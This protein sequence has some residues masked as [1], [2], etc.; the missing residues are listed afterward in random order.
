M[1]KHKPH[2]LLAVL[3][4]A[5]TITIGI[6]SCKKTPEDIGLPLLPGSDLLNASFTDAATLTTH[7]V[8]DDSVR[9]DEASVQLLGKYYDPIFGIASSSLYA[10]MAP[11]VFTPN[12][13]TNPLLDSAVLSLV[14][15]NKTY[16]GTLEPQMFKVYEIIENI[17]YDAN[18]YSNRTLKKGTELGSI[19]ITPNVKDS[20]SVGAGK[21][22]AHIRINLRD[23][24]FQEF[25]TNTTNYGSNSSFQDFFKGIYVESAAGVSTGYGAIFSIDLQHTYSRISLFYHNDDTT[26]QVIYFN[27][28][29]N[30][31]SCGRFSHFE[32]DYSVTTDVKAQLSSS[33][34][35]Q[36]DKIY[37]QPMGGVRTK[38]SM[39][40]IEN[41]FAGQKV[42]INKA[43]LI[44]HA[45]PTAVDSPYYAHSK[46]IATIADSVLGPAVMPDYYEGDSYFGGSYDAT[47]K[48]YKFNIA[49]Y[50]QQVVNGT[51]EN[52]GLYIIANSRQITVNRTQLIGG[53]Q[54]LTNRMRL[55]ITYTPINN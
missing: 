7:T 43:E 8:K 46:L 52:Q 16:Y 51:R 5:V 48:L 35:I 14:Y 11:S 37:I 45:E 18:Y 40:D 25:L 17:D 19:T 49:R 34:L 15:Y 13:G 42:A 29:V 28:T 22:P 2:L 23:D 32:H 3:L 47:N 24:F 6:V 1:Y 36:Q 55:K 21:Y 26:G 54:L 10:E 53:S 20:I 9:T 39:P 31:C 30:N 44:M 33:D 12:F 50:I 41:I 27:T 38:I 4:F